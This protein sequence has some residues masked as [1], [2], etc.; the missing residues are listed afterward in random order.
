MCSFIDQWRALIN[1]RRSFINQRLLINKR[2]HW[3]IFKSLTNH[4]VHCQINVF[5][6][7]VFIS[8]KSRIR[9]KT[10]RTWSFCNLQ[11]KS[12]MSLRILQSWRLKSLRIRCSLK[13]IEICSLQNIKNSITI[14]KSSLIIIHFIYRVEVEFLSSSLKARQSNVKSLF[15]RRTLFDHWLHASTIICDETCVVQLV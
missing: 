9:T 5:T 10:K 12:L 3:S 8:Q 1:Q 14:F 2:V 13:L 15:D 7:A 6:T 4:L 11:S